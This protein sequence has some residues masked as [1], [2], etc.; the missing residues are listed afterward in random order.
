MHLVITVS[1]SRET[2][3]KR[4]KTLIDAMLHAVCAGV[5]VKKKRKANGNNQKKKTEHEA[6]TRVWRGC[7]AVSPATPSPAGSRI[8][9][10]GA[11]F[12]YQDGGG[13]QT[14]HC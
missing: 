14:F 11:K 3:R 2:E 8:A 4:R 10:L 6:F 13:G 12:I 1:L 9:W 7:W 5:G